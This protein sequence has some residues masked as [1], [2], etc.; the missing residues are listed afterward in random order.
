MGSGP[1]WLLIAAI[2]L[3]GL[4]EWVWGYRS[5]MSRVTAEINAQ[6]ARPV[7]PSPL[8]AAKAHLFTRDE[9]NAFLA[10]AKRAEAIKDPLQRCIAYPDPPGSH[11][12]HDAVVAYCH[13]GLQPLMSFAEAQTLIQHGQS[14]ELDRRL[15]AALHA[16][17][18]QPDSPGL[19]DRTYQKSFQ[20]GSFEIRPTLDAW[21]RD[22]PN[23]AF[24]WAASGVAYVAMAS[25][26]RGTNYMRDTPQDSVD[27]MDNLLAQA[28]SDLRKAIALDPKVTPAHSALIHAGGLGFGRKYTDDAIAGGIA[29]APDDYSIYSMAIWSQQP[30][31]GGSLA[32][33]RRLAAQ[34][35]AHASDNPALKLMLSEQPF[36]VVSNCDCAQEVELAAYPE[37][38]DQLASVPDLME[39][40]DAAKGSQHPAVAVIYLSEALR[41]GPEFDDAR[42]H[43]LEALI[44]F[45]EAAWA[46]ADATSLI[47]AKPGDATL[48]EARANAYE[49]LNDYAHAEQDFRAM[50]ALDPNDTHAL[51]QL[52]H[53]L[54]Y[55]T[56]DWNGGW[57]VANQL[58]KAQPQSPYG[59]ILRANIQQQQPRAGLKDTVEYFEA[60]FSGD[61]QM[62][63]IITQMRS[64]LI[65]QTHSGTQVLAGK[66][67]PHG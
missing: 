22:S 43:R 65:L 56:H 5:V 13:F 46:V 25:A 50:L 6:S 24:A 14:A 19:L 40:G 21:K 39:A 12:S 67:P 1:R 51:V 3:L 31:W 34:A 30:K 29:A 52:G 42:L 9:A 7:A 11:W 4:G 35:Q 33:M 58:I 17:Q 48:F 27:S 32:G 37:A 44:D 66:A 26:A 8:L 54:V 53:M 41:F 18:T 55:W 16:Q 10:A 61:P 2:V 38:L 60:H 63:Q 64:A 45:D 28:D 47:A 23:S 36:Y 15:A 57:D 49:S 59:W 20:N 62:G